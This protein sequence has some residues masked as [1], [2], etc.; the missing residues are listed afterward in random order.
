[1]DAWTEQQLKKME[2]GGNTKMNAFFKQYGV[3]KSCPTKKKYNSQA[4]EV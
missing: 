4:A 3:D 1:M 2:K